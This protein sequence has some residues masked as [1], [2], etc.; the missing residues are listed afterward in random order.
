M[1]ERDINNWTGGAPTPTQYVN[2]DADFEDLIQGVFVV[3]AITSQL[4][5]SYTA[6]DYYADPGVDNIGP[7]PGAPWKAFK[8]IW[9]EQLDSNNYLIVN[10]CYNP[11]GWNM[12]SSEVLELTG[13]AAPAKVILEVMPDPNLLAEDAKTY[14]IEQPACVIRR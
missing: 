6:A 8:P 7:G 4:V 14:P 5:W 13:P 1:Y 3:N 10:H 2:N 9:A 11:T 12:R